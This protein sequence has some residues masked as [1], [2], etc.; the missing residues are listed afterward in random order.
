VISSAGGSKIP[1]VNLLV[2]DT[3]QIPRFARDDNH[4]MF[5]QIFSSIDT[6]YRYV[7]PF[8]MGNNQAQK[9]RT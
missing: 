3:L 1:R 6:R 9:G 4:E 5:Q 7:G 8:E 2:S